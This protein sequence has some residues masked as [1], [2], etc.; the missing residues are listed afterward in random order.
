M[1]IYRY[2]DVITLYAEALVRKNNTVSQTSLNYLNEIRVKHGGLTAYRMSEVSDIN[3]FLEKMLEERGHE[4]YFEGV[5][6]QDLIRHGKFIE[7]AIEKNQFAGQSTEKVATMAEGKYKY[8]LYPL[9][10]ALITEGQGVIKQ[11]PGY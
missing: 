3:V 11:N 6:R 10:L 2:A 4:F 8:E 5:R 1:V 9:P 7:K